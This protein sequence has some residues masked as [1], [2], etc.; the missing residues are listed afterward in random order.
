M[1]GTVAVQV[2]GLPTQERMHFSSWFERNLSRVSDVLDNLRG[3]D[4]KAC[5]QAKMARSPFQTGHKV[6]NEQFG[7]PPF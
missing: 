7:P 2:H 5:I 6:A 1:C 4:C 3:F